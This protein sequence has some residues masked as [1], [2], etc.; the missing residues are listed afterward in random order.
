MW[1]SLCDPATFATNLDSLVE[2]VASTLAVESRAISPIGSADA[3][4]ERQRER[5]AL[6]NVR[7]EID[8]E[9]ANLDADEA[10]ALAPL[11]AEVPALGDSF[12]STAGVHKVK[13]ALLDDVIDD[14]RTVAVTSQ[15]HKVG[16]FG[17]GGIGKTVLAAAVA[18]DLDVRRRFEIICW[19]TLGQQPD[20]QKSLSLLHIQV[21]ETG[22]I[23]ACLCS[24]LLHLDTE[25]NLTAHMPNFMHVQVT[26][27][28]LNADKSIE[29]SRQLLTIALRGRKCLLIIDDVWEA[30]H[31]QACNCVDVAVR[32]RTLATTRIRGL[33]SNAGQVEIGLPSEDDSI[34]LLLTAAGLSHLP[35]PFPPEAAEVITLCGRLPLALDIAGGLLKD[36]GVGE[37]WTG[38]PKMFQQEM[39]RAVSEDE[40]QNALEYRVIGAS[41]RSISP[42]Y[43]DSAATVLSAFA[44]VAEDEMVPPG[45][46]QLI[47]KAVAGDK[48]PTLQNPLGVRKVLQILINRSIVLGSWERPQLHVR[49]LP[50]SKVFL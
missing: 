35:R 44:L 11:P 4:A 7:Q 13:G 14:G 5:A 37:D 10:A 46:F 21:T 50:R 32:S 6:D 8:S 30:K 19:V 26:G 31:E 3:A 2:Q 34:A 29:E 1:T 9:P 25:V 18:R 16:A 40:Q 41:L 17:M 33:V 43:H 20:L 45:A 39:R 47:V 49:C 23:A 48:D 27:K 24:M 36:L 15:I 12:R 22:P 42:R 28:E 38:V